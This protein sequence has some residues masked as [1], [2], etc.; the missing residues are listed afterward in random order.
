M[1]TLT[2][3]KDMH[4][5][6][7]SLR[8]HT[9]PLNIDRNRRH[10][11]VRGTPTLGTPASIT[12]DAKCIATR[13]IGYGMITA[14]LISFTAI[15]ALQTN[16]WLQPH[17]GGIRNSSYCEPPAPFS[18]QEPINAWSNTVYF[19]VSFSVFRRLKDVRDP[20]ALKR[21]AFLV[22]IALTFIG[23][24]ISSFYFHA[25]FVRSW[26]SA[27][28]AFTRAVPIG[29]FG[30]CISRFLY[31]WLST[32]VF[33][34]TLIVQSLSF[35]WGTQPT[36]IITISGLICIELIVRPVLRLS[37]VWSWICSACSLVLFLVSYII[38]QLEVSGELCLFSNWFQPHAIWH[39]GTGLASAL[40]LYVWR[41]DV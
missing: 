13:W 24:A 4:C 37:S 1:R 41:D 25:S 18:I 5:N 14:S 6:K 23:L 22:T 12:T 10:S 9:L 15:S 26:R 40:Q 39:F 21:Q 2:V 38:R 31:G 11:T 34:L 7:V 36:F 35:M 3:N 20:E 30:Y 28:K 16:I 29:L 17:W 19:G 27:D 33:G 32:I 8:F